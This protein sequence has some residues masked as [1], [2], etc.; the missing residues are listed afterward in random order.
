MSSSEEEKE[1]IP[2]P[3]SR[4]RFTDMDPLRQEK[5]IRSKIYVG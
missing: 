4:I 3:Q 5:A 2:L 1:E